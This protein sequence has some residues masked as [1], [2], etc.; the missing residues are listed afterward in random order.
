[1]K[2]VSDQHSGVH[3]N[4][5]YRVLFPCEVRALGK[6]VV[7]DFAYEVEKKPCIETTSVR[8]C[9]IISV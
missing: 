3:G 2:G 7:L 4:T 5:S 8:L 6:E 9:P 1:M